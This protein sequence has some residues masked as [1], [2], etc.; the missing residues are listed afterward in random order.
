MRELV[1]IDCSRNHADFPIFFN[2]PDPA[3]REH[4]VW[5]HIDN[6]FAEP[7]D[8]SDDAAEYVP[9][10][11]ITEMFKREGYDGIAY[12]SAFGKKGFNI[13]LFDIDAAELINCF[14]YKVT[15]VSFEFSETANPYFVDKHYKSK[16]KN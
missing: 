1:V 13:V 11:I 16:D 4:A 8:R 10:Q 6:A 15:N 12:K 14:L 9:T 3:E 2:E 5:A 7:V